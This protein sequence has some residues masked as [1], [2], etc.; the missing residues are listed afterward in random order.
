VLAIPKAVTAVVDAC[1]AAAAIEP[2]QATVEAATTACRSLV[3]GRA[4]P[5][6]PA[7]LGIGAR[8]PSH[9]VHA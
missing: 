8:G 6:I 3:A 9:P 4:V 1:V 5:Q 7:H 2:A